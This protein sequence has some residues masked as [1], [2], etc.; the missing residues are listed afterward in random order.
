MKD[1]KKLQKRIKESDSFEFSDVSAKKFQF[2]I[3][4][5]TN[6]ESNLFE[7]EILSRRLRELAFLNR[8]V[9]IKLTDEIGDRESE[10]HYEGGLVSYCEFLAK[11]KTYFNWPNSAI[12]LPYAG[13]FNKS[14]LYLYA[15]MYSKNLEVLTLC[16]YYK[17]I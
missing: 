16:L 7:F 5:A 10:F 14:T 11:G 8:G 17:I 15:N 3:E 2:A 6:V 9:R 4:R 13:S 1:V 12:F